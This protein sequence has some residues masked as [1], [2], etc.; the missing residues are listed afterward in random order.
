MSLQPL[1]N[2][3]N[4]N[5][6]GSNGS[7]THL[8]GEMVHSNIFS[9]LGSRALSQLRECSREHRAMTIQSFRANLTD[10][11]NAMIKE[12]CKGSEE[13]IELGNTL[14]ET[15]ITGDSME[16]IT[17]SLCEQLH[18]IC[19]ATENSDEFYSQLHTHFLESK[20]Y[21]VIT[22]FFQLHDN[23]ENRRWGI[24]SVLEMIFESP[25]ELDHIQ[26]CVKLINMMPND[27]TQTQV[28]CRMQIAIYLAS[29]GAEEKARA[30][31]PTIDPNN[32]DSE[33]R[34]NALNA[35]NQICERRQ[36]LGLQ[37]GK[38]ITAEQM[39]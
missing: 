27:S 6:E 2:N 22:T 26:Y 38:M 21:V 10:H 9:L 13:L 39:Q 36:Q 4:I 25:K 19:A 20:N 16:A 12:L 34:T 30:L 37:E 1:T 5:S 28:M 7:L 24:G 35:V 8:D 3:P 15:P 29:F 33:E 17:R 32:A 11:R 23:E 14:L 18:Q 31:I